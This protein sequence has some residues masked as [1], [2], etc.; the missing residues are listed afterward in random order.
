MMIMED[1]R[2]TDPY[3][4]DKIYLENMRK[5]GQPPTLTVPTKKEAAKRL[6]LINEIG[7]MAKGYNIRFPFEEN[8][9]NSGQVIGIEKEPCKKEDIMYV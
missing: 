6:Q 5:K 3:L 1:D 4:T 9:T 8:I 2:H 7:M